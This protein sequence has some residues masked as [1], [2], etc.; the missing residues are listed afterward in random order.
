MIVNGTLVEDKICT[1]TLES[2]HIIFNKCP[3]SIRDGASA[4]FVTN[5]QETDYSVRI[6]RNTVMED[7]YM[8]NVDATKRLD[9]DHLHPLLERPRQT[10][11]GRESNPCR[12]LASK[13]RILAKSYFFEQLTTISPYVDR[14]LCNAIFKISR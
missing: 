5:S 2:T 12:S 10:C 7:M 11:L 9:Q 14:N 4:K 13:A 3:I 6:P 1:F 8:Q